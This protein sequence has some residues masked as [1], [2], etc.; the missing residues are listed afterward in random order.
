MD[1]IAKA[2]AAPTEAP[3]AFDDGSNGFV[4]DA[5]HAADRATFDA[6]EGADEGLGPLYNAQSCREC[7]QSPV[8][9]AASQ[10]TELRVGHTDRSGNFVDPDIALG[11]GT[12]VVHARSL[13]NDRSI[14]PSAEFP[15]LVGQEHA[16]AGENVRALRASLNTLGDGF[17]EA[18]PSSTLRALAQQQCQSTRGAVCGRVI[19]VPVLEAGGVQRV[20]RFGWKNQHASLLS[21]SADAYLNEMGVTSALQPTDVTQLCDAIQ[22]PEDHVGSDGLGDVDR[23]ARFMRASKAPPRYA[24]LANSPDG[25]AGSELFDQIG[26]NVCH[27]RT[28]VTAP[29]GSVLNGGTLTVSDSVGNKII[30]PFGDFLLHD[31][32]TGDGIVQNGG[33]GTANLLRTQPLWGVHVR[34]RLMHDLRSL[35]FDDAI[36]RHGGEAR[37]AA[38]RYRALGPDDQRRLK[39]FLGSL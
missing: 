18:V 9:G 17:V 14:C 20:G 29:P 7:H 15:D 6:V 37:S 1:V 23:F 39:V 33:Q 8:S 2:S 21:F 16:P 24:A 36:A 4:D 26:C 32:G 28:L 19:T 38:A 34:G 25:I 10:V 35:T 3:A 22:D 12:E 5:T 13:V 30:H 27:V 31:I 11:D